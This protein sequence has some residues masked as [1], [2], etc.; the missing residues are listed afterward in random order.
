MTKK[1]A[2]KI[3]SETN[4]MHMQVYI[5]DYIRERETEREILAWAREKKIKD[6]G[7]IRCIRSED[8]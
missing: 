8:N 2:K 3:V 5:K 6:L 1:E 4:L 7:N